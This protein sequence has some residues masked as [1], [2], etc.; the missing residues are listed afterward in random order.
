MTPVEKAQKAFRLLEEA[1]L[2]VLR[3]EYPNGVGPADM[4]KTL[5]IYRGAESS[6][7]GPRLNDGIVTTVLDRLEEDGKIVNDRA[8]SRGRKGRRYIR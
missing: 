1:V 4:S 7:G 2:E 8:G 3:E 6:M 5:Q